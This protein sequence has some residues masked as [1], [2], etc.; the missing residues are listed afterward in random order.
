MKASHMAEVKVKGNGERGV[1]FSSFL[2]LLYKALAGHCLSHAI[3]SE[4]GKKR[5]R[6]LVL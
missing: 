2:E 6:I 3:F 5:W 4:K 1:A